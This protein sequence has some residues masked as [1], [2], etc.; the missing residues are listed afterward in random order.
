MKKLIAMMLALV[1]ALSLVACGQK[2]DTDDTA[3]D[4]NDTKEL[5]YAVEAGSAGEEAAAEKGY[6]T[7]PVDTQAKALMEVDAGTADAAVIDLLMAYAMVGEGTSYPT[8]KVTDQ[9]LTTE[10][11]GVGC[12]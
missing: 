9:Q 6:K 2:S 12:R 10:E 8:L 1:M 4:T 3:D 11:Y 5:T 7:V